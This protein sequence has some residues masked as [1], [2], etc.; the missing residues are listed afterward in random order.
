[1]IVKKIYRRPTLAVHGGATEQTKSRLTGDCH[2]S[3][4]GYRF[5]W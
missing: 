4:G 1:M 3:M 5:C 2:D